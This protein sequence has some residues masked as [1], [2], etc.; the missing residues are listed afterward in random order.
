M[1][2]SLLRTLVRTL[3]TAGNLGSDLIVNRPQDPSPPRSRPPCTPAR[4]SRHSTAPCLGTCNALPPSPTNRICTFYVTLQAGSER[5]ARAIVTS[6]CV[7]YVYVQQNGFLHV[8]YMDRSRPQ[9]FKPKWRERNKDY[10]YRN[11][12]DKKGTRHLQHRA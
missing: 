7:F 1:L 5:V 10:R 11:V 4:R 6:I 2:I 8:T 12:N 9:S 3:F